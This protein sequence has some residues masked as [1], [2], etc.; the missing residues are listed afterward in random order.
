MKN[1]LKNGNLKAVTEVLRKEI[2]QYGMIYDIN[3]LLLRMTNEKF[4]PKYYVRYLK[5][6]FE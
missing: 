6:K 5:E 3:E 1:K 4:N 2:H